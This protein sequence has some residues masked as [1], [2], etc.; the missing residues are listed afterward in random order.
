MQEELKPEPTSL[1]AG[2]GILSQSL[3][4][5]ST[6]TRTVYHQLHDARSNVMQRW[7]AGIPLIQFFMFSQCLLGHQADQAI[8]NESAGSSLI[9]IGE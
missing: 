7:L 2:M 9:G 6:I 8:H 4:E 3:T 5:S 1:N